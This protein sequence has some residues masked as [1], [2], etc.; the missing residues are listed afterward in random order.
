MAKRRNTKGRKAGTRNLK[1]IGGGVVNQH[2]IA[3]T[4]EERKALNN[5]VKRANKLR[6]KM[7][8]E[9][10]HLPRKYGGVDSGDTRRSL[11]LMGQESDFIIA[12]KS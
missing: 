12:H 1:K 8:E 5:A 7:L 2:N 4:D 3:F 6:N 9:E 11:Q 10:S